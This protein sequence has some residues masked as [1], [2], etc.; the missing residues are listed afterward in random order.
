VLA[1]LNSEIELIGAPGV[2]LGTTIGHIVW[3]S[4]ALAELLERVVEEV[5][6]DT[7]KDSD[8]ALATKVPFGLPSSGQ[9]LRVGEGFSRTEIEDAAKTAVDHLGLL[10]GTRL[11]AM[12]GDLEN[13]F[14]DKV[15]RELRTALREAFA[16]VSRRAKYYSDAAE[17]EWEMKKRK[18][19][20]EH[21][22]SQDLHPR[23]RTPFLPRAAE[24]ALRRHTLLWALRVDAEHDPQ[25]GR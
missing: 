12:L 24:A 2:C 11:A 4:T 22:H 8:K 17:Y 5:L 7:W 25:D 19:M 10:K 20:L 1:A 14:E 9:A 16:H 23:F 21:S 3:R 15:E 13:G 6:S 18:V